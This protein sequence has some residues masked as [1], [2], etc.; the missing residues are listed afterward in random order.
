MSDSCA[1][2]LL[3]AVFRGGLTVVFWRCFNVAVPRRSALKALASK[4][5]FRDESQEN[6]A[7][8]RDLGET[9]MC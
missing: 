7:I 9:A 6:I 3:R 1:G 5:C 8:L 2:C 4:V